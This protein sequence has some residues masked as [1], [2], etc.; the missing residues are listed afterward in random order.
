MSR[1]KIQGVLSVVTAV[2]ILS[3]AALLMA[4]TGHNL[5]V[6]PI[7][8]QVVATGIPGAG[9]IAQIGTFHLGGPFHDNP[10]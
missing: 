4:Q 6:V 8:A 1:V 9:A 3:L 2:S 5:N 10:A 7:K